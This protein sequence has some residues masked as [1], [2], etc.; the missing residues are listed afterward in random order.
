MEI[1]SQ[2]QVYFD[3][4]IVSILKFYSHG[5]DLFFCLSGST[6][7]LNLWDIRANK[8]VHE[9][10][11]GLGIDFSDDGK[12]FASS[13]DISSE[14]IYCCLGFSDSSS[15]IKSSLCGSL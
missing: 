5:N 7:A 9:Y 6:G 10:L 3:Y 1:G 8:V 13:C 2:I 11:R 4:Q 14:E 15:F 12:H